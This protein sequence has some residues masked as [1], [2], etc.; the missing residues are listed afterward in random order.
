M[1]YLLGLWEGWKLLD[2]GFGGVCDVLL[3]PSQY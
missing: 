2:E 1:H 3:E